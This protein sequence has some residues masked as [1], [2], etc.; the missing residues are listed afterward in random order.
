MRKKGYP[1]F[2]LPSL[3]ELQQKFPH[4]TL[5]DFSVGWN[6]NAYLLFYSV[7]SESLVDYIVAELLI[8]WEKQCCLGQNLYP[9]GAQEFTYH[10]VQ[11]LGEDFLL[12][13][14]RAA[15]RSGNPEQN[16]LVIGRD[17]GVKRKMCLGDGIQNCVVKSDGTILISYF[18]EGIFG[19]YGWD[20]P[21]GSSGLIAW[22]SDGEILWKNTQYDID[23]CYA[24]SLD[25]DENTWFYYYLDFHLVKTDFQT[26]EVFETPMEGSSAFAVDCTGGKF[27]FQGGY[28]ESQKFYALS[29]QA[30]KLIRD[31]EI[32]LTVDGKEI[33]VA[34]CSLLRPQMLFLSQDAVLYGCDLCAQGD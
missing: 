2:A 10:F 28:E 27:L 22:N 25:S 20:A 26:D 33:C 19:N 8:D 14:A 16:G 12:V 4:M 18:D 32:V 15:Y 21:I 3:A 17:G 1:V 11:A 30:G 23:D 34:Q 9:L 6:G 29:K 31:E 7:D 24:L 13:G 5:A